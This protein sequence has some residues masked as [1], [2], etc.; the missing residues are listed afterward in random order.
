MTPPRILPNAGSCDV[1]AL[2]GGGA[3]WVYLTGAELIIDRVRADGTP[4]TTVRTPALK[5]LGPN[6]TVPS[7]YLRAAASP[8]GSVVAGYQGQDGRLYVTIDGL[9]LRAF[10]LAFGGHPVGFYWSA[11]SSRFVALVMRSTVQL[12]RIEIPSG[13]VLEKIAVKS[14]AQG[15]RDVR[16][17]G[18][19][20]LADNATEAS[21]GGLNL[22]EPMTR[23]AVTVG[24]MSA[25]I[26]AVAAGGWWLAIAEPFPQVAY[27]PHIAV[28]LGTVLVC[29]RTSQG[30]T[31]ARFPPPYPLQMNVPVAGLPPMLTGC[32]FGEI[33]GRYKTTTRA[34][35]NCAVINEAGLKPEASRL[36]IA[37]V[38]DEGAD[39]I[40]EYRDRWSRVAAIYV[41]A[42]KASTEA[43]LETAIGAARQR[44][45]AL[46][47]PHRPVIAYSGGNVWPDLTADW[48]AVQ[49]YIEPG[50][51]VNVAE[52]RW[53]NALQAYVKRDVVL[54]CDT[55][56]RDGTVDEARLA[57]ALL[58][59]PEIARA[60]PQ[61]RAML[62][63]SWARVGG[64][65][66]HPTLIPQATL[67]L[68]AAPIPPIVTVEPGMTDP[69]I[70]MVEWHPAQKGKTLSDINLGN[71]IR[72]RHAIDASGDLV[73]TT[74]LN[75][76]QTDQTGVD[77]KVL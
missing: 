57:T 31:L 63:F 75:G 74:W 32:F 45:D 35:G 52:H 53:R 20:V 15:L 38:S 67:A 29:A 14:T 39:L 10:G 9:P 72:I 6:Q 12:E 48:L 54:V 1:V 11:A 71:G 59:F 47:L 28:D 55:Y 13:T 76:R 44:M 42:E 77:R 17:D 16:P 40:L 21:V 70:T 56:D 62:C 8:A 22:H 24:Q 26:A 5:A 41:A 4:W 34:P 27:E 25:G 18:S 66:A 2:P 69:T 43:A 19:F 60:T 51:A 58:R 61:C 37:R 49:A 68:N 23:G 64:L 46:G 30:A 7:G 73:V 36:V 33:G 65:L 50:E 3:A